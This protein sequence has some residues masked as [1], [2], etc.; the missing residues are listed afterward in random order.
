MAT[1]EDRKAENEAAF[2]DA[3]ERIR[4][5]H[6]ELEPAL[7][8]VPYL[9]EC[10]EASCRETIRLT[11]AEYE[12]VRS[13]P[14]WFVIVPGHPTSGDVVEQGDGFRIVEKTGVAAQ[15]AVELDPRQDG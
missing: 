4:E 3:N 9:C 8:R 1:S 10:E 12:R 15:V 14:T 11:P 2:R 13:D 7:E 5:V 6:R